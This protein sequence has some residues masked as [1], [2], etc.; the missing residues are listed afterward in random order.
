MKISLVLILTWMACFS[1]ATEIV[2]ADYESQTQSLI[3]ELAFVGGNQEHQFSLQWDSCQERG[4]VKEIAARLVDSGH[5]DAGRNELT[6][7][8]KFD[9]SSLQCR[10]AWLTLRSGRFSHKTLWVY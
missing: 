2:Q 4:L 3:L 10:P 7:T 9:L 8:V 1:Q 5:G 6:Q